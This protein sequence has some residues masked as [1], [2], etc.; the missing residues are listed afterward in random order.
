MT[1]RI[2]LSRRAAARELACSVEVVIRLATGGLIA[3]RRLPTAHVQ[4]LAS[5]VKNIKDISVSHRAVQRLDTSAQQI[6]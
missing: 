2:W 4:Y 5:D 3:T 6:A 1:D